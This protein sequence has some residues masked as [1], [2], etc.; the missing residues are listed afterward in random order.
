V[1]VTPD[2]LT[3]EMAASAHRAGLVSELLYVTA[4]GAS[5]AESEDEEGRVVD[6]DGER[7]SRPARERICDAINARNGAKP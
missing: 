2:T 6:P 1:K 3:D 5:G 7:K 4:I